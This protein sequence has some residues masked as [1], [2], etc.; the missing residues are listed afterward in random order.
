MIPALVDIHGVW[1]VLPPGIHDA[2]MDEV[3][4]RFATSAHRKELFKG[5]R[6]GVESLKRAGCRTIFLD[7]SFI[8]SKT[9]PGD[10]DACWDPVGVDDKKLDRVLLDLRFP[11]LAQKATFK[12]EFFPSSARAD[13]VSTFVD[14]FQKDKDSGKAKGILRIRLS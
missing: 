12:G 6:K 8:T 14:Y 4:R 3:E 2:T 1:E 11:R 13:G 10:F 7:G 9:L 5:F